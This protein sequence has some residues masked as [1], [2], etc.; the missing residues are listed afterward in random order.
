[1]QLGETNLS[2][3]EDSILCIIYQ[4]IF[5]M[6]LYECVCVQWYTLTLLRLVEY[7]TVEKLTVKKKPKCVCFL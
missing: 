7:E 4:T 6:T 2:F 5:M 3:S 1:M